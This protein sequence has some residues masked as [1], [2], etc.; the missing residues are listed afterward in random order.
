MLTVVITVK[1]Y[2]FVTADNSS[3]GP[4]L[5][6]GFV[7]FV[8]NTLFFSIHTFIFSSYLVLQLQRVNLD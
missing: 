8:D 6:G 5:V 7:I 2:A 4:V 1:L 3:N